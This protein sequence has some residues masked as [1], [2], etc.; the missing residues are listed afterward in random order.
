CPLCGQAL[1]DAFADVQAHRRGEA[2]TAAAA[3]AALEAEQG[4]RDGR[5][6][7]SRARATALAR[8]LKEAQ[9]AWA[10]FERARDRRADADRARDAAVAALGRPLDDGEPDTRRLEVERRRTAARECDQLRGRLARRPD[11][12]AGLKTQRDRVA[13]AA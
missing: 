1:G 10:G 12:E 8:T 7:A 11:V 5:A 9:R 3:I 13:D 2:E 6:A 4:E